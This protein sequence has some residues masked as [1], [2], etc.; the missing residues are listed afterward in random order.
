MPP[1]SSGGGFGCGF[2][3]MP[4]FP[5]DW[6]RSCKPDEL[7]ITQ[8]LTSNVTSYSAESLLIVALAMVESERFFSQVSEQVE[9]LHAYIGS[10]DSPLQE[11]PEVFHAVCMDVP[12]DI[13]FGVV[14]D[15]VNVLILKAFVGL[16]RIRED[17][18]ARLDILSNL[19]SVDH[20]C[21][22]DA[23]TVRPVPLQKTHH[24]WLATTCPVRIDFP[25]LAR[26]FRPATWRLPRR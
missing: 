14:D 4:R 8:P 11:R 17:F 6:R 7:I 15:F 16:E 24:G 9:V 21:S 3:F 23:V 22:H 25:A 13:G 26:R 12:S 5:L 18:A 19:R 10:F 1:E 2:R 20:F